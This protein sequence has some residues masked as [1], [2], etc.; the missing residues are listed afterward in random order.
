MTTGL[1]DQQPVSSIS[2]NRDSI[3]FW[4]ATGLLAVFYV[5]WLFLNPIN[6]D[7]GFFAYS[8]SLMLNGAR[9]YR[10][11][12][13]PNAP[14]PYL[15]GAL[16]AA[17]GRTVGLAP[18]PAFLLIFTIV[19]VVVIYRTSRIL[20]R[21][22]AGRPYAAALL[23]VLVTFCLFPYVKDSFGEREHILTCMILPWLFASSSDSEVR[24]RREQV[25]DGL[26]AGIGISMKPYFIA[27]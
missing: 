6:G 22:L 8:G 25:V 26:M 4:I 7:T 13:E 21:L 27:V 18:A 24:S 2:L 3:P 23:T 1:K 10:D 16:S 20:N 15:F 9:L 17:L 12:V 5:P 14:T 11:I 19:V